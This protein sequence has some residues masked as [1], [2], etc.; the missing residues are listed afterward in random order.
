MSSSSSLLPPVSSSSTSILTNTSR[1]KRQ[2]RDEEE[3][4]SYGDDEYQKIQRTPK[5]KKEMENIEQTFEDTK[6]ALNEYENELKATTFEIN[7]LDQTID[8]LN[9]QA[10]SSNSKYER[11]KQELISST[12]NRDNVKFLLQDFDQKSQK[13]AETDAFYET[14]SSE[15]E[16][17]RKRIQILDQDND[18][19]S[20]QKDMLL[21]QIES[22]RQKEDALRR[23]NDEYIQKLESQNRSN[24]DLLNKSHTQQINSLIDNQRT[25]SEEYNN[26]SAALNKIINDLNARFESTKNQQ[27]E[28]YRSLQLELST[29]RNQLLQLENERQEALRRRTSEIDSLRE[30]HRAQIDRLE[31]AYESKSNKQQEMY[32][33][34]KSRLNNTIDRLNEQISEMT[35]EK[36]Q[37]Q[38]D[39][40]NQSR[41][42]EELELN[43]VRQKLEKDLLE[44]QINNLKD[45]LAELAKPSTSSSSSSSLV[46]DDNNVSPNS[47]IIKAITDDVIKV[48]EDLNIVTTKL[49]KAKLRKKDLNERIESLENN[50]KELVDNIAD[51][52]DNLNEEVSGIR[53]ELKDMSNRIEEQNNTIQQLQTEMIQKQQ[54]LQRTDKLI[55]QHDTD[56]N[57]ASSSSKKK[58]LSEQEKQIL[59][60]L[61][62]HQ[63]T[64]QS[65]LK[66]LTGKIDQ[67]KKDQTNEISKIQKINQE[68]KMMN[69]LQ[70]QIFDLFSK[71]QKSSSSSSSLFYQQQQQKD[72]IPSSSSS[73][74][75]KDDDN[76]NNDK[77]KWYQ[78]QQLSSK[79]NNTEKLDIIDISTYQPEISIDA[80]RWRTK[81]TGIIDNL[82]LG[83]PNKV[84]QSVEALLTKNHPNEK[85]FFHTFYELTQIIEGSIYAKEGSMWTAPT[86]DLNHLIKSIV[87]AASEKIFT[88]PIKDADYFPISQGELQTGIYY[89]LSK[90]IAPPSSSLTLSKSSLPP[91]PQRPLLTPT[92]FKE[93]VPKFVNPNNNNNANNTT[94]PELI[95]PSTGDY[96]TYMEKKIQKNDQKVLSNAKKL[97]SSSSSFSSSASLPLQSFI[98]AKKQ[99]TLSST[100][101]SSLSKS[102]S[103]TIPTNNYNQLKR[104]NLYNDYRYPNAPLISLEQRTKFQQNN[105]DDDNNQTKKVLFDYEGKYLLFYTDFRDILQKDIINRMN[106]GH[107]EYVI[108][109]QEGKRHDWTSVEAGHS[110]YDLSYYFAQHLWDNLQI[111][112]LRGGTIRRPSIL[113][114]QKFLNNQAI[115]RVKNA[116][117]DIDNTYNEPWQQKIQAMLMQAVSKALF[118]A[119]KSALNDI[120]VSFDPTNPILSDIISETSFHEL[121]KCRMNY[122]KTSVG[123]GGYKSA[124]ILNSS[125]SNVSTQIDTT[126]RE[127]YSKRL[128]SKKPNT[129]LSSSSSSSSFSSSSSSLFQNNNNLITNNGSY[130]ILDL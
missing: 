22:L 73:S 85:R 34:E 111:R 115:D 104:H 61:K 75:C 76:L 112:Q 102:S 88:I 67:I 19:I 40:N 57:I 94:A 91:L 41:R 105:N 80:E 21:Q 3:N 110:L 43:L 97:Q 124:A 7:Q 4:I 106:N 15:L 33:A 120:G 52:K 90:Y 8:D 65:E 118:A 27:S 99:K 116:I 6:K 1:E 30:Q 81:L 62:D 96:R 89:E 129:I 98:G 86:T 20:N 126:I 56:N 87:E 18:R 39:F 84:Y 54:E 50:I 66:D 32:D 64:I 12:G 46:N 82:D 24:I 14:Y 47:Q 45:E 122:N 31:Q 38:N 101:V 128:I 77:P 117:T 25:L 107:P 70:E 10:S 11:I 100:S 121:V 108:E 2:R 125:F 95:S 16:D 69:N 13:I 55:S 93:G 42:I 49:E 127:L 114:I 28:E 78:H 26:T 37:Q 79:N 59:K 23:Q 68:E 72:N 17:L 74:I 63:K 53:E 60:I 119:F 58:S 103:P 123:H 92:E 44:V 71:F 5:D 51:L 130:S 9:V 36:N 113:S 35:L 29:K 83:N 48:R 109:F